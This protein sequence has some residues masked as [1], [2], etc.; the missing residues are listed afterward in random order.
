MDNMD[1]PTDGYTLHIP[2]VQHVSMCVSC[3]CVTAAGHLNPPRVI[4]F[5]AKSAV[6]AAPSR[7]S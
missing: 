6:S 4:T 7:R 3:V 1:V 5:V 2:T